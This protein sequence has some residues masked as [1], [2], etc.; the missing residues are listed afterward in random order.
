MNLDDA[1]KRLHEYNKYKS[2]RNGF[3]K[4]FGCEIE[5]W[6]YWYAEDELYLI[7]RDQDEAMWTVK[8]RSPLEA[9]QKVIEKAC[10]GHTIC[11]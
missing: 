1:V 7:I 4:L 3:E 8:A 5:G 2:P 9:L 10:D 11:K 6:S